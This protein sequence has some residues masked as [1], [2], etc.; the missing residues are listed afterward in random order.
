MR[1]IGVACVLSA[2]LLPCRALPAAAPASAPATRP[3]TRPSDTAIRKLVASLAAPDWKARERAQNDLIALGVDARPLLEKILTDAADPEIRTRL[4]AALRAIEKNDRFSPTLI[5]L[6]VNSVPAQTVLA[7]L[8]RQ[9]GTEITFWPE[10]HFQHNP[11]VVTLSLQRQPF[12]LAVRSFCEQVKVAPQVM[13]GRSGI[14]LGIAQNNAFARRPYTMHGPFMVVANGIT[15]THNVDFG[16]PANSAPSVQARFQVLVDPKLRVLKGPSHL[17]L[18]EITDEKGQSLIPQQLGRS[19]LNS[20]SW[21]T[22]WTWDF[23]VPLKWTPQTG[24]RIASIKGAA[25]FLIEANQERWEINNVLN[26]KEQTKTIGDATYTFQ[27]LRKNGG[28]VEVKVVMNHPG[29]ANAPHAMDYS[30]LQQSL[31][32]VDQQ[33]R[34]WAQSGGGGGGG[35]RVEYSVSFWNQSNPNAPVGDPA[36]LIWTI[37]TEF[38]EVEVPIQFKDLPLP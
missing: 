21:G 27:S 14:T 37:P 13:G 10:H 11:A 29:R 16:D 28:N 7:E 12:W 33:G 5:T 19:R 31:T 35:D 4:E 15:R 38:R 6:D 18:T 20:P 24:Q 22:S 2:M 25:R 9:S 30:M 34:R 32:L 23:T 3:S 17:E 36:R 1:M 26:A 8:T